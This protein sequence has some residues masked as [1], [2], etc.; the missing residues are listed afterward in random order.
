MSRLA[1]LTKPFRR[2]DLSRSQIDPLLEL[3]GNLLRSETVLGGDRLG[4]RARIIVNEP[5]SPRLLPAPRVDDLGMRVGERVGHYG[6]IQG[7]SAVGRQ[8]AAG[9]QISAVLTHLVDRRQPGIDGIDVATIEGSQC[10][11]RLQIHKPNITG[12]QAVLGQRGQQAVMC[13]GGERGPHAFALEARD[14][15]DAAAIAGHQ[16]LVVTGHIKHEGD[17]VRDVQGCREPP[18]EGTRAQRPEIQ[19]PG[20]E[21]RVD[22]GARVES[23]PLDIVIGQCRFQPTVLLDHKITAGEVLVS[24]PN[25]RLTVLQARMVDG[26]PR[27]HRHRHSECGG[28]IVQSHIFPRHGT[29]RRSTARSAASI[30]SPE[31]PIEKIPTSTTGVLL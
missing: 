11:L 28:E 12:R 5:E 31:M 10:G 2:A 27:Q 25:G 21:G 7:G 30:T 24:D 1:L 16:R 29:A 23:R 26:A 6:K 13:R 20:D 4:R 19:F 17:S 22:V 14:R 15:A 18:R 9:D 3:I 8:L